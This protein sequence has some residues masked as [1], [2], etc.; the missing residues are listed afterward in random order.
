M[1]SAEHVINLARELGYLYSSSKSPLVREEVLQL[2]PFGKV[3]RTRYGGKKWDIVGV[4][5]VMHVSRFTQSGPAS[6]SDS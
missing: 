6:N 4:C 5:F 2:G 3:S 1:D